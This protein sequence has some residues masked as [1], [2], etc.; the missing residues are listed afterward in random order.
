MPILSFAKDNLKYYQLTKQL[1][2]RDVAGRYRGSQL[3]MAWTVINPLLMLSVYTLV[4]SQVFK[5]RWGAGTE[6]QSP[7]AFAL[8]LFAGLLVFNFFAECANRSPT[9]ITSNPNYVKKIVF[10]L[11][12]LGTTIVGSA[13]VHALTST[14]ILILA[15][16]IID[17]QVPITC[18]LLPLV[19]IPL[20]LGT[21]GMSWLLS[22]AGVFLRDIGQL[23][24][25]I[26]SMLMFLSPIFYPASAL[27]KGLQWLA[28]LNP[29]ASSIEQ[30]RGI[31]IAGEVPELTQWVIQVI[32][33]ILW[34]EFCFRMLQRAKPNFGDML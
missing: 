22:S 24:G 25:A 27:P 33:S 30:T 9:L 14:A 18:L 17:R 32:V 15:K 28:S 13:L 10:P 19:W 21:L 11:H 4:F 12:V 1:I 20:V 16:L 31:L 2:T 23:T 6:P 5:A 8:N 34:C 7:L 3:G 29:L 26:V